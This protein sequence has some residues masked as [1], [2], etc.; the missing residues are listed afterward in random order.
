[1][2][3][4]YLSL[5]SVF[6]LAAAELL[7]QKLLNDKNAVN[8]RTSAVL[9]FLVQALFV[10]PFILF[11]P[12]HREFFAIFNPAIRFNVIAVTVIG[13]VAMIFYLK[14]FRVKNISIS[15]IFVAC[16]TIISTSLGILFFQE[17]T[18]LLKYLGIA[19][20]L[21]SIISLNIKN[22]TLEKNHFYG[23]LAGIGFGINYTLDKGS[24]M[25]VH[26][27]VYLFWVFLFVALLGFLLGPRD[28]LSCLKGKNFTILKPIIASGFGYVLYNVCTFFAYTYGGEVGRIDAINNSQVF[29]IILFEYF[30]LKHSKG[31]GRK[32]LTAA[33]AYTGVVILGLL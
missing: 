28:V 25:Y 5:L 8:E 10:L 11:S 6:G 1:M 15:A 20:V 7:Q 4:F 27:L 26:P 31:M 24:L 12:L 23:L 19:L 30:I 33:I 2:S 9:T 16:S 29:L 13:A 22:A 18:S 17:S 21:L 14:S 3:W 32:L